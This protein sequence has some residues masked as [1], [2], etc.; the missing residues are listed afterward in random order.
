MDGGG[1]SMQSNDDRSAEKSMDVYLNSIGL[2]R[3]KIAKDGSCLFRAVAE[4]VLHCQSLHTEVRAK[5]VKFLKE[6]RETY[7]AFIEGDFE[8]YL[9]KLQDPQQWVGEVE[10][11]AL[12]VMYKRDFL[13]FQEP[14]K[15]PVNITDNSYKDKVRLC[16]LNGNHYDSV[17]PMSYIKNAAI[18]QSILYELLYGGVFKA[19]RNTLDRFSQRASRHSDLLIDDNMAACASSDE[20]DVDPGDTLWVENGTNATGTRHSGQNYRG[21]GRGWFSERVKRS[22]NPTLFRN[23]E[24]DMWHKTKRAQQKLDYSIA[25]GMQYAVGD[26]CQVCLN[27]SGRCYN[28]TIKDVSPSNGP[29]TV[30]ME[31]LGRKQVPLSSLRPLREEN[32]WRTVAN[33]DKRLSNGHGGE[34]EERVRGKGRGKSLPPSSSV[35]QGTAVGSGGRLQK[36]SSWPPQ[37]VVEEQGAARTIS[38]KAACSVDSP[39]FGLT[40]QERLAKEEE[41]RNVALVE[42]Q[43]RDETS[44]P[45]LGTQ[46][47]VQGEGGRRKGGEKRRSQKAVKLKSPVDDIGAPSP[48][49]GER[50]K[51][52]S[53]PLASPAAAPAQASPAPPSTKPPPTSPVNSDPG[54]ARVSTFKSP[55]EN[56]VA[57][58]ASASSPPLKSV[59]ANCAA[60]AAPCT[61]SALTP[62]TNTSASRANVV[63]VKG[64]VSTS[65]APLS[66]TPSAALLSVAPVLPAAAP[67]PSPP[68]T[69]TTTSSPPLAPNSSPCV[70]LCSSGSAPTFIAPIAPSAVAAQG[71]PPPSSLSFSSFLPITPLP[72]CSSPQ[73]SSS[74]LRRSPPPC[75]ASSASSPPA[76]FPS[77]SGSLMGSCTIQTITQDPQ[78]HTASLAQMA[79][80]LTQ[81]DVVPHVLTAPQPTQAHMAPHTL[82]TT[83]VHMAAH[84]LTAPQMTQAHVVPHTTKAHIAPHT[85]PAPQMTQAHIAP[86]TLPAL[87]LTQAHVVPQ[88]TQ[89]HV[90]P[91]SLAAPQTTQAHVVPHSLTAPQAPYAHTAAQAQTHTRFPQQQNQT[92]FPQ[93]EVP[94]LQNS[95]SHKQILAHPT[96]NK[97]HIS[98]HQTSSLVPQTQIQAHQ[99]DTEMSSTQIQTGASSDQSQAHVQQDSQS[100]TEGTSVPQTLYCFSQSSQSVSQLQP[101]HIPV[102]S[103]NPSFSQTSVSAPAQAQVSHPVP[104][105]Q[106]APSPQPSHLPRQSSLL[107]TSQNHPPPQN[108]DQSEAPPPPTQGFSMDH[109]P[110]QQSHPPHPQFHPAHPH[111]HPSYHQSIAAAIPLQQLYQ[112]PLYPGFPQGEKGDVAMIPP[113][114][115]SPAGEDLPQDVNILKFFFNLGVK[116][117]SMPIFPPYIYLLPL[118]QAHTMHPKIPSRSPSPAHHYPPSTPPIRQQSE[119]LSSQYPPASASVP[120]QY[121]HHAAPTE[122]THPSE[123][124]FSQTGYSVTHRMP[125]ALLPWQ[126]QQL[127]PPR[128]PNYSSGYPA[129]TAH[130]P[131]PPPSSQGYHQGQVSGHPLYPTTAHQYPASS[132]VYPS[133]T[134]PSELQVTQGTMEAF[135]HANSEALANLASGPGQ[136]PSPLEGF[137]A[138]NVAN[139]NSC[140]TSAVAALPSLALTKKD[141]RE[142]LTRAVLLVDP[143]LN[144]NPILTW[145]SDPEV[146]DVSMTTLSK[147]SNTPVLP[148]MYDVIAKPAGPSDGSHTSRPYRGQRKLANPS[149]AFVPV[150]TEGGQVGFMATDSLSVGCSTE[151]NWDESE[152]FSSNQRGSRKNSGRGG[153]GRGS[154]HRGSR[155]LYRGRQGDTG[156]GFGYVQFNATQRGRGRERGY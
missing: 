118:H 120:P 115:S 50:P 78:V 126:Q 138:A 110:L 95:A 148:A 117:Y 19:D 153:R 144:N 116:A 88:M 72:Q 84:S 151:D 87:Q 86:H 42:L 112:D 152:G 59:A 89:A 61:S 24:Y 17:Y 122:P 62:K 104:D 155:G 15:P 97:V 133:L 7:E 40:E 55:K 75:V 29:V 82:P 136:V 68:T 49:A 74:L 123:S 79:P 13:I 36:Q 70:S 16:F 73:P 21:R 22:L 12:A 27:G 100:H 45:A 119:V 109:P 53:P 54:P 5:C 37:A 108:Q 140:R 48:S 47:T 30:Y 14:G 125:C 35:S 90:A 64:T 60:A 102:Q 94:L 2:H 71:F 80:Q 129:S 147:S 3:K 46:P 76:A 51:S 38:R 93:P 52:S 99:P 33:R 6:N 121:D 106:P 58:A 132:L 96:Q 103:C 111:P 92:R 101:E 43:L 128:N 69:T 150:V 44:F 57:T 154:F 91:H 18:C 130:Y 137:T 31:E 20:S 8:E 4:Q 32:S 146:K 81:A 127:P 135:Q 142:S 156:G 124:T 105:D 139:A 131:T 56:V 11:N 149:K 25:A 98:H 34:W 107:S 114:S 67:P 143:P 134:S 77:T 10:M 1:G 28:A 145:V 85:L 39:L 26:R 83:Q 63:R 66:V 141:Q 23:V 41:E 9:C 65:A 113:Y